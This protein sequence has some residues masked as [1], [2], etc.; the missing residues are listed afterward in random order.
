MTNKSDQTETL[1]FKPIVCKKC[2][3]TYTREEEFFSKTSRWRQ[4]SRHHLWFNCQCGSTMMM[5]K[6][7]VPWYSPDT[8]MSVGAK[9]IFNSLARKDLVPLLPIELV[10]IQTAL[11]SENSS[12]DQVVESI[13]KSPF[14]AQE[15]ISLANT[16]RPA[17]S[18]E[19]S[20]IRHALVYC[21]RSSVAELVT[22]AFVR[23]IKTS[24]KVFDLEAHWRQSLLT[25]QISER[26]ARALNLSKDGSDEFF[27]AGAFSN[28]GKV[29]AALL[30]PDNV[31]KVEFEIAAGREHCWS[32]AEERLNIPSHVT[33]GEVGGALW[34]FRPSTI[35]AIAR[36]HTPTQE[37]CSQMGLVVALANQL[38]HWTMLE[39]SRLDH[40]LMTY[41]QN[42]LGVPS[43]LM[44]SVVA[45]YMAL[46]A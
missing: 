30:Y 19:I 2:T 29:L 12:A 45:E 36:H 11:Q 25:G 35:E 24:C 42:R 33:L 4:C 14:I 31:D 10:E 6:G 41:C 13:R 40:K 17:N 5:G 20:S 26:L 37:G 18:G 39:T 23:Q 22:M 9:S 3:R 7:S 1:S 32:R 27:L 46:G 21:G 38:A 44:D 15:I 28:V 8:H 16:N 43:K 34:G